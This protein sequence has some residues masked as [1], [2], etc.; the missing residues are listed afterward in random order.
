MGVA[1]VA[2]VAAAASAVA[3]AGT[4]VAVAVVLTFAGCC[5]AASL[6]FSR[7]FAG[8]WQFERIL[9][10]IQQHAWLHQSVADKPRR[11]C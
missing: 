8:R 5:S 9:E 1:V 11:L 10:Y 3:A 2:A 4:A 6:D 7:T